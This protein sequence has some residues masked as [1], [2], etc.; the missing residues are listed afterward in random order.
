MFYIVAF[1]FGGLAIVSIVLILIGLFLSPSIFLT[2]KEFLKTKAFK[3]LIGFFI[4]TYFF[5][6]LLMLPQLEWLVN[7]NF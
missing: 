6:L 4:A 3:V 2:I 7:I 1:A 5:S